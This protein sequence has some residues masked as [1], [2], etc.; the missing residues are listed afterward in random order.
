[1][2]RLEHKTALVIGGE[3]GMGY[4]AAKEFL[5][6]GATVIITARNEKKLHEAVKSL[7]SGAQGILS[8]AEVMNDVKSL[9]D[10][11][12]SMA[13]SLDVIFLNDEH[14]SI[15]ALE[16]NKTDYFDAMEESYAEGVSFAIQQL[17][18]IIHNG[19]SIVVN[20]TTA[21]TKAIPGYSA[22]SSKG[23]VILTKTLTHE[24][25]ARNIRVNSVSAG[26]FFEP[27]TTILFL[28]SDDSS[29][30]AGIDLA[31]DGD[32][33]DSSKALTERLPQQLKV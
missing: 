33:T 20:R 19:A 22:M 31:V 5:V 2:K 14:S 12:R 28:A 3:S 15:Q 7:G 25:A 1:M 11:V 9:K 21:L 16:T 4:A 26:G 13:N 6:E 18:S 10:K 17:L 8:D 29:Y 30:V 27:S 24:L 32:K 23:R